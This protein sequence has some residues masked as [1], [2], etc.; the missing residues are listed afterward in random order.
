MRL[1]LAVS[2]AI[3]RLN[4]GF[5]RIAAWLV[6]IACLISAGNATSRYLLDLSSNAWLE[7]QWYLF[8][9]MVL[10][11]APYVLNINE[12]VRVDIFYGR[13]QPR[14]KAWID[15]LGL[16]FFLMPMVV[17]MMIMSWPFFVESYL[18]GEMSSNAGGL[19]R[20]PVKFIVPIG[21]G[22]LALQGLGEIVKRAAYLRGLIAM[23]AHYEKPLQ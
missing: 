13:A 5:G 22:L 11:G 16:V 17:A 14:T 2:R 6:L 21:F 15:L 10:F 23:D 18:H 20:W 3:D 8:F 9:A 19:L 12:H 7:L 4:E 1:L